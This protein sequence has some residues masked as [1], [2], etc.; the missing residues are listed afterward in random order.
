M[1]VLESEGWRGGREML[2]L[3]VTVV[4]EAR[5]GGCVLARK[6][7]IHQHRLQPKEQT[8]WSSRQAALEKEPA[9]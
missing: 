3:A 2:S 4:G 1:H 9:L 7:R 6:G 8:R 5:K